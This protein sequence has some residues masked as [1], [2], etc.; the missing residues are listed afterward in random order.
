[1]DQPSL[2]ESARLLPRLTPDL[3]RRFGAEY[4][5]RIRPTL[6]VLAP[7]LAA[8]FAA[9]AV[10]D[11]ADTHSLGLA[12]A[13]DGTPAALFLVA[14]AL[15]WVPAFGRV[16]QPALTA[17]G[18]A[19]ALVSLG[20][21]AAFLGMPAADAGGIPH[22]PAGGP[23]SGRPLLFGLQVCLLM[24]CLTVLRLRFRWALA[25]EAGVFG[26][27]VWAFV[28]HLS[29]GPGPGG[30]L[31]GFLRPVVA[32]LAAVLLAALVNEQLA[33]RAF[34]AG[35]LL[36]EE[37]NDERRRREQTE[38]QL[39]VLAQAIGGIVH[40]LGNPLTTV[41]LGADLLEMQAG[42]GNAA[43][44]RETNG[45]VREG[46]QMLAAL[47][48]SLI[49]QTRV[50]EGRPIPVDLRPEPLR[51]IVEAGARF[52][53]PRLTH[54]RAVSLAEEDLEVRA[55][56]LKLVTVFM[57]LIGN[58]LKYSDGEV[59]VV[60]RA[61]GDAVL[62]GVLDQGAGGR[63]ISEAQ[64][65]RLFVPFGRLDAHAQVEGTG[66]GL[67]SARKI[68]EAHGGELFIEGHEGG[69]PASPPFTTAAGQYPSLLAPGF[70]TGFLIACPAPRHPGV[71][72]TG[73]SPAVL[74]ATYH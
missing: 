59:R 4:Y 53:S 19:A 37:R 34:T 48:L 21:M 39:R 9:C 69:T 54:G 10:R 8:L 56:R 52:Q 50:L 33:V 6:R 2:G 60:W 30:G 72:R 65:Q 61:A 73:V 45:A 17:A 42:S 22:G 25:L 63:G 20:A 14:F 7:F 29:A 18:L 49:E 5:A 55:D 40:D 67:V 3:E 32:I 58:A 70:L 41:Q 27:G 44:I 13:Q 68:V 12:A 47:R 64:A 24:V 35:H 26:A 74:T 31:L 46:A 43:A 51:P 1:M 28:A 38:G 11:Y 66:L 71:T 15:T 62:V 57:N 36:E 16:W 23:P